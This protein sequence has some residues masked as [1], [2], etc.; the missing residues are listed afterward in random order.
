MLDARA[1]KAPAL[2][3]NANTCQC[4]SGWEGKPW[5]RK[6]GPEGELE[7]QW[8]RVALRTNPP[9]DR[10]RRRHCYCLHC[11]QHP[12]NGHRRRQAPTH[13]PFLKGGELDRRPAAGL[14][15]ACGAQDSCGAGRMLDARARKAP[16]LPRKAKT[17][18]GRSGWAGKLRGRKEGRRASL[19]RNGHGW[20]C[21]QTLPP[22]DGG[23]AIVIAYTA[24]SIPTMATAAAKHQPAALF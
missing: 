5:G 20:H 19:S 22:T 16:A 12:N 2:Q 23:G 8:P 1:R 21:G 17:C 15:S 3:R 18:Q 24:R 7:P 4:R 9:S 6:R 10:R 14:R 11:V 13:R